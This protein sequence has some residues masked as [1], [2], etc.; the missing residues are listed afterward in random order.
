MS[1]PTKRKRRIPLHLPRGGAEFPVMKLVNKLARCV[2]TRYAGSYQRD[3]SKLHNPAVTAMQYDNVDDFRHDYLLYNIIRKYN[4]ADQGS[5]DSRQL[6]A[7]DAFIRVEDSLEDVNTYLNWTTLACEKPVAHHILWRASRKI[8]SLLGSFDLLSVVEESAFSHGA[9]MKHKRVEGR[10]SY[11]YAY[12]YP[13][14]TPQCA[15]LAWLIISSSHVWSATVRGLTLV[16]GNRLTT[17]PKDNDKDRV[18]ACE[19]TMNMYIQKGVGTIIRRKLKTVNIDL[20]NQGINQEMARLGSTGN[21]LATIDLSAASDS[22]SLALCKLLLDTDWYH[23]LLMLR[24]DTGVLP[25]GTEITYRKM[26][27]MGN[28]FTFELESLLFWAIA[29]SCE[30]YISEICGTKNHQCSVYGDDIICRC[31]TVDALRYILQICGFALNDDKSFWDGPFRESCGKHYFNG[32]D[33]SPFFIRRPI[34]TILDLM[35]TCNR[36]RRWNRSTLVLMILVIHR[37][38][39]GALLSCL[40]IGRKHASRMVWAMALY[41]AHSMRF[42]LILRMVVIARQSSLIP[43]FV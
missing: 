34:K 43:R 11:K 2:P 24:S 15:D 31:G 9:S 20:D 42:Y 25:D 3:S 12:A 39:S 6:A 7:I 26:S 1:K 35:G 38:T 23:F 4:A 40:G 18:I 17:V 37:F 29:Q 22:I 30:D 10:A 13:E 28:G 5:A 8:S 16:G 27:S 19:P 36:L 33:V 32:I 41:S 14:V 21:D